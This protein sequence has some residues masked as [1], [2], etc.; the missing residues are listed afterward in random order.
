MID[1]VLGSGP[2][3]LE[4]PGSISGAAGAYPT[5]VFQ[6]PLLDITQAVS[7]IEIL[8]ARPG[9]FPFNILSQWVI[10]S[11]TGAQTVPATIRAGSDPAHLN[12]YPSINTAPS[13]A[14]VNA[15]V[16]PSLADAL[17]T[18]GV[19]LKKFPGAPVF[20]DITAPAAG[21]GGYSCKARLVILVVWYVSGT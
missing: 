8:P 12:F 11:V 5:E 10:E 13:N 9:Y 20:F 19:A 17:N 6:T 7:N 18:T 4:G 16:P 3:M 15:A 2:Q 14:N 21:T 1:S